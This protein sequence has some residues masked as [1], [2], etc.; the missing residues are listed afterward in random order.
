M[1]KPPKCDYTFRTADERELNTL[2]LSKACSSLSGPNAWQGLH[3]LCTYVCNI[4]KVDFSLLIRD[5]MIRTIK[6]LKKPNL[7]LIFE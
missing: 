2:Q 4:C 3:V 7:S 5:S 6:N 1:W